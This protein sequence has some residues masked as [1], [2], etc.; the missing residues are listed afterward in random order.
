MEEWSAPLTQGRAPPTPAHPREG[1]GDPGG[2]KEGQ[3]HSTGDSGSSG[4][5]ERVKDDL[6][7]PL[8]PLGVFTF[9]PVSVIRSCF[10][11]SVAAWRLRTT[12]RIMIRMMIYNSSVKH[13]LVVPP[14]IYNS[15]VKHLLVIPPMHELLNSDWPQVKLSIVSSL[16]VII[17]SRIYLSH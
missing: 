16:M 12:K 11:E 3:R 17:I 10:N 9:H 2:C 13:L 14:M 15:S 1:R 7:V 8:T 6:K 5:A 4:R